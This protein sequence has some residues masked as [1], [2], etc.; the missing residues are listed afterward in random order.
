[1]GV[2][3]DNNSEG[4]E[5]PSNLP[6]INKNSQIVKSKDALK[7]R[8]SNRTNGQYM[9]HGANDSTIGSTAVG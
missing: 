7:S 8:G 4:Y 2:T 5:R 1:M 9:M 3:I 6:S